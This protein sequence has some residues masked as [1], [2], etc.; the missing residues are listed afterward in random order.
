MFDELGVGVIDAFMLKGAEAAAVEGES[1]CC[2]PIAAAA[3]VA[4]RACD[5]GRK[6]FGRRDG[7]LL[8]WRSSCRAMNAPTRHSVRATLISGINA[9]SRLSEDERM[10][11]RVEGRRRVDHS[12]PPFLLLCSSPTSAFGGET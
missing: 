2:S 12:T 7:Y 10:R 11:R 1:A 9:V 8:R 3:A 5:P 6:Q 4:V